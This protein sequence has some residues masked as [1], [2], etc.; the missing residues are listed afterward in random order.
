[1]PFIPDY[2]QA[3]INHLRSLRKHDQQIILDEVERQLTHQPDEPTRNRKKLANNFLAPWEFR[4]GDFRVFYEVKHEEALVVILAIGYKIHER[5]FIG[6]E[7]I[8]L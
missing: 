3:A 8:E 1:M 7:E 6:G 4:V 5:L 2:S